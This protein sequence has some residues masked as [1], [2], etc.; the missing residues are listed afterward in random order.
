[1]GGN[2]SSSRKKSGGGGGSYTT[3]ANKSEQQVL[4]ETEQLKAMPAG[5]KIEVRN[6]ATGKY[7]TFIAHDQARMGRNGRYLRQRKFSKVS[8][9]KNLGLK[10]TSTTDPY[11][12]ASNQWRIVK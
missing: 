9:D 10:T 6:R 4:R 11:R 5:T 7:E 1:M 12:I 2:G 3:S 8:P